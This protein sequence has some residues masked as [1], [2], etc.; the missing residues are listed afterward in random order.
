MASR[1]AIS[2][3]TS[4]GSYSVV[5]APKNDQPLKD[6]DQTLGQTVQDGINENLD[7]G[8]ATL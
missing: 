5:R 8:G 6:R 2:T 1:Q 3:S 7:V 4:L